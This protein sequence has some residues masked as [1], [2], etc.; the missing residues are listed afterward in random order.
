MTKARFVYTLWIG[1]LFS[2]HNGLADNYALILGG[3]GGEK[4]FYDEFW[5]ATSRMH[6]LLTDEYGYSP[7]NISFLFEDS[8]E[9]PKLVDGESTKANVEN[10][11]A[12]MA[13]KVQSTDRFVL[14]MVGHATKAGR[15]LKFNLPG[16]DFSDVEVADG[17]NQISAEEMILIL[18][19][20]YSARMVPHFSKIGRTIIVSCSSHE[21]YMRSGF[22][23]IFIDAFSD[24]TSD[25]DGN[26]AIS[27]LEAFLYAQNRVKMW[28]EKDG[29][30]Q[31]EHPHL[32]DNGDGVPSRKKFS[33]EA[34]GS[35][36]GQTFFGKRR[37][38]LEISAASPD[39]GD[40][41]ADSDETQSMA[42]AEVLDERGGEKTSETTIQSL[43]KP[44]TVASPIPYNF[45]SKADEQ[46]IKM[47]VSDAT[48]TDRYP[49]ANAVVLWEVEVLNINEDVSSVYSTRRIVKILNEG[50]HKFGGVNIP[51]TRGNDDITLHHART[52]ASNGQVF[53]LDRRKIVKDIPP[54][55]AVER[56]LFVDARLM[57]FKMPEMPDSYIV[58][59][60]YSSKNR[61][62]IMR[63]EFWRQVYFQTSVPV[64]YYR[65]TVHIPK[66][67][68]LYYQING[69]QIEPV[70]TESNYART[71][72]FEVR[73]VPPLHQE[74]FMPANEDLAYNISISSI[75]SWEML[76][77]WYATLI[78][79]Q[80]FITPEIEEKT[81]ALLKGAWTRK[82]KIKR[83]YEYVAANINYVGIELGIWAIKPHPAP[84]IL[85]E[86][87]GDCKDKTT[88]LSTMLA[89]TGI[90]SYPVLISAGDSRSVV[91][92][93]PS[94]A[95][96]NHMILAVEEND[97]NADLI[98]LDSTVETCAFGDFPASNQDRWALIINPD[99]LMEDIPEQ[100]R[101]RADQSSF[102]HQREEHETSE[103][104]TSR[105]FRFAK[106][107]TS[108]PEQNL[109]R[110]VTQI[111]V[112]GDLSVK[113]IQE[114]T[115][116]GEFN[117]KLRSKL[118]NLRPDERAKF[119]HRYLELDSRATLDS[120]E[121]SDFGM[122]SERL[123]ISLKWRC[124]DYL[125]AI[126]RQFVLKLPVVK[127]PYESLLS[128]QSRTYPVVLGGTLTFEDEIT[129]NLASQFVADSV[130]ENRELHNSLGSVQINY[131]KSKRKLSMKQILRL[132]QPRVEVDQVPALKD[133]VR[134]ASNKGTKHMVLI[135]P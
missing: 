48:A 10:V 62:H 42:G 103:R 16:R 3:A 100:G 33:T 101:S 99:F 104:M 64:Q 86:K 90:R 75:D 53:E 21:G 110:T 63:G 54:P 102:K 133:L 93:I 69:P 7:E 131:T 19:F 22:G 96:F 94:L 31:S 41:S 127:H 40:F 107:P 35:L 51:Y 27:L 52:I 5:R 65:F 28:Y 109:K 119:L 71:Y 29:A 45:I 98:W 83:L 95:Y 85:K 47:L 70:I 106:S 58:D 80:D 46:Q 76:V 13:Q 32:D 72:I 73:D 38:P 128:E 108:P 4:S 11:L 77:E 121:I 132:Q 39:F 114:I 23:N 57:H 61:G 1:I 56:G 124:S 17:I 9:L 123:K 134:L 18:G 113:S 59:Y 87:Y 82:E 89:A 105:L 97:D 79:E 26:R 111:Q 67:K 14:F 8:G 92:E 84:L 118:R 20:P 2:A 66:K 55:S 12:E 50:G 15:G 43:D 88:L 116:T 60:A 30:V 36:A 74:V 37:S 68:T 34:D 115:L 49:D 78:R 135:Q 130:P 25:T 129:V 6:N 24:E 44:T 126:G 125:F 120:F 81:K 117:T 91:R 112:E 122:I